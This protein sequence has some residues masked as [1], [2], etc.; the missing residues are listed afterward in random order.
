MCVCVC[1]EEGDRESGFPLLLGKQAA[2]NEVRL[3]KVFFHVFSA[4]QLQMIRNNGF[5]RGFVTNSQQHYKISMQTAL[6]LHSKP[7]VL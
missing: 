4:Y 3:V 6:Y 1:V 5:L 7:C 2:V